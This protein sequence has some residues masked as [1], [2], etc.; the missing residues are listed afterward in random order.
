MLANLWYH[1]VCAPTFALWIC[2][3]QLSHDLVSVVLV[4]CALILGVMQIR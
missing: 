1:F 2:D 4:S 3:T